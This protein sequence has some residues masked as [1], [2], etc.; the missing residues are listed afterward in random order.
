MGEVVSEIVGL[1]VGVL[2]GD[3]VRLTIGLAVCGV[4]G[5]SFGEVVG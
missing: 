1:F 5:E 4:M 3:G 2:V